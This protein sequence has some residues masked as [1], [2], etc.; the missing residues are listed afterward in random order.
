MYHDSR[1]FTMIELLIVIIIFSTVAVAVFPKV[2]VFT[3]HSRVNQAAM[4]VAQDMAQAVTDAQR[5]R[6]PVRIA[7]GADM[8]SITISDRASGTVLSTRSLGATD[9]YALDSVSFSVTPV[10]VFPNGFT[11]SALTITLWD[12]QYSRQVT[13]SR[14]GWVTLP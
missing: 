8:V 7:R 5:Q 9:P 11:S 1:G 6:K 14:A 4:V 2:H 12:E 3:T 10:D 13:M